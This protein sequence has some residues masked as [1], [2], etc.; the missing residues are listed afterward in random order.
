[1]HCNEI[2]TGTIYVSKQCNM[3]TVYFI[4]NCAYTSPKYEYQE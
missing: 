2:K 4:C 1:M 3:N